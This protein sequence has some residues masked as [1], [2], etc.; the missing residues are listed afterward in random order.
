MKSDNESRQMYLKTIFNLSACTPKVRKT[1]I[2]K[3]LNY[4]K[5]SVTY[6]VRKLISDGMV[7]NEDGGIF[8]TEKGLEIAEK[9]NEKSTVLTSFFTQLGADESVAKENACRIEH[10][11]TDE[12]FEIIRKKVM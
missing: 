7:T 2:A 9:L 11:I 6:A 8:L 4:S 1:D 3:E 12:L 10:D 5:P